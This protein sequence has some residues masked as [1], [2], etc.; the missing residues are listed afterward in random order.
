[1][2]M[3]LNTE[4]THQVVGSPATHREE[5]VLPTPAELKLQMPA[6]DDIVRQV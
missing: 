4:L 5:V 1:M 2:N 3:S 6:S